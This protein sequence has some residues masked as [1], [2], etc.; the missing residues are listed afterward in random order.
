[1]I[2]YFAPLG[3]FDWTRGACGSREIAMENRTVLI[4]GGGIAGLCTG[5]YLRRLGFDTCVTQDLPFPAGE[6]GE[7]RHGK[8]TGASHP[9]AAVTGLSRTAVSPRGPVP[10]TEVWATMARA[11]MEKARGTGPDSRG[12]GHTFDAFSRL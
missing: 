4:V 5:V 2:V 6:R 12:M 10:S 9:P 7:P 8:H 11:P 1:M 3:P